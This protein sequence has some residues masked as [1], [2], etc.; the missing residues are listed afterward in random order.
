M[1]RRGPSS[2]LTA[3]GFTPYVDRLYQRLLPLSGRETAQIAVS[4]LTTPEDL[5]A[6]VRPLVEAGVVRVEGPRIVVA[7]P[8]EAVT[9]LVDEQVRLA[10]GARD[11]LE[12]VAAAL[13][14]LAAGAARPTA[15]EVDE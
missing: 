3:L 11:R 5:L 12:G 6:R 4:M 8:L 1:A 10:A 13:P 9:A 14:F 15:D 2:L 7:P